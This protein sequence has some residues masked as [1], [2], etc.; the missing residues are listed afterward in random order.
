[1]SRIPTTMTFNWGATGSRRE[2]ATHHRLHP[3]PSLGAFAQQACSEEYRQVGRGK[4]S[5]RRDDEV[6]LI[7]G[8]TK[9]ACVGSALSGLNAL[10][11]R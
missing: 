1:V 10:Y 6:C 5:R 11:F 3:S 8:G 4:V 7:S 9:D 2:D